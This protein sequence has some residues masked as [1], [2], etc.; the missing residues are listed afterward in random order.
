MDAA[1]LTQLES[2]FRDRGGAA[3]LN[4][5][6]DALRRQGEFTTL[7]YAMLMAKRHELGLDP[8]PT[9]PVSDVPVEQ[10]TEFENTIRTAAE[11]CG[12]LYLDA[13][14]IPQAWTFFRM[15]GDPTPVRK[16][17]DRINLEEVEDLEPLVQIAY[18]EGVHPMRGFDWLL[19]RY[20]LCSAITTLSSQELPQAAAVRE[21]VISRVVGTLYQEL[22]ERLAAEIERLG[23]QLSPEAAAPEGTPGVV[24]SLIADHPELFVEEAYHIDTSHLSSCVQLAMH[25]EAG[26]ALEQARELCEYGSHLKGRWSHPG[27][28]P[29]EDLYASAGKYLAIL[30]GD[31]VEENLAFFREEAD[32]ADPETVGTF[33]AEVLV[34]LLLKLNR[35]QEALE[36][37]R[38]Y[39]TAA[40]NRR[41]SCPSIFELCTRLGDYSS[42]A[43]TAR[44]QGDAIHFLAGLLGKPG[45]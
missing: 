26:P 39:L 32:K 11:T 22:R 45:N 3:A 44:T 4:H 13:N 6:C 18:Y 42:L 24:R 35:P 15:I 25:L 21:H 36:A 37:A 23:G 12:Q 41:L 38:K 1:L 9:N 2:T 29:F 27:D 40:G 8:V 31:H 5:L 16:A 28:P 10:Q 33:P 30:A 20:G 7:F 17:L 43:E 19:G 14:Q 34:N